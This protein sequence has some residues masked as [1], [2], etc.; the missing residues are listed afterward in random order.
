MTNLSQKNKNGNLTIVVITN[1][2]ISEIA[3]IDLLPQISDSI[4]IVSSIAGDEPVDKNF[5]V[6]YSQ[7]RHF[8]Y[9]RNLGA[10][11]AQTPYVLAID[12]DEKLSDNFAGELRALKIVS[13]L[14]CIETRMFLGN[15]ELKSAKLNSVRLYNKE[16]YFFIGKVHERLYGPKIECKSIPVTISNHSYSSWENEKERSKKVAM[17]GRKSI[18]LILSTLYPIVNYFKNAGWTDGF[19]GV[20]WTYRGIIAAILR[21]AYGSKHFEILEEPEIRKKLEVDTISETERKYILHM[22]NYSYN[23]TNID[24]IETNRKVLLDVR[25][26]ISSVFLKE[27]AEK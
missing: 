1:R 7:S 20:K 9:L 26:Q 2:K 16:K 12:S 23:Q 27:N 13:D 19:D 10:F 5:K 4:I 24:G 3:A 21:M 6:I 17:R 8:S 14:Y 22:I 15:K 11:Y 18:R 25:E